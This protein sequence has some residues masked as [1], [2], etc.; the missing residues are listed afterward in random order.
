[1]AAAYE[2]RP[3]TLGELLDR[4]FT[5][6]RRHFVLLAGISLLPRVLPLAL[7]A[8]TATLTPPGARLVPETIPVM[9]LVYVLVL[10]ASLV[11]QAATVRAVSTLLLGEDT[12][13]GRAYAQTRGSF[14]RLV[15]FTFIAGLTALGIA[16]VCLLPGLVAA[17]SS[18]Q[19][20][21]GVLLALGAMAAAVITIVVMLGW[22]VAVPALLQEGLPAGVALRR[23][24]ALVAGHR[25]RAFVL[26]LIVVALIMAA[27]MASALPFQLMLRFGSVHGQG[28]RALRVIVGV[29]PSLAG[30]LV[31]PL[32]HTLNTLFY[33]DLRIRK[34]GF[35]V[36]HLLGRL[37]GASPAPGFATL[38]APVER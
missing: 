35:D 16:V 3:L 32:G 15:G 34:E 11:A 8:W 22:S 24:W 38:T 31:A 10:A 30:I 2:L 9:V 26:G 20:L 29:M 19:F 33:Y 23:S 14:A 17:G 28:A 21:F 5:I 37:G 18:H 27:A 4:G 7:T 12:S 13:I 36:E 1:M 6:V 25:G